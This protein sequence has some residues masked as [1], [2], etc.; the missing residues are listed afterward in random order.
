V[1]RK[2]NKAGVAKAID[3]LLQEEKKP[4]K[5]IRVPV[6]QYEPNVV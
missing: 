1:W 4:T 5:T 6:Y 2:S 3:Q